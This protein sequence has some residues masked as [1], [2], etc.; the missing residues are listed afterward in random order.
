M[1]TNKN[2]SGIEECLKNW[3]KSL[4]HTSLTPCDIEE[5]SIHLMESYEELLLLNLSEQEAWIIASHRI[6]KPEVLNQE[7]EKVNADF[8]INRNWMMLLWGAVSL[9]I[10]QAV[11]IV[12]PMIFK[13]SIIN[14]FNPSDNAVFIKNQY[15]TIAVIV[16]ILFVL[17]AIRNGQIIRKFTNSL[18]K[19]ASLYGIIAIVAGLWA[20]FFSYIGFVKGIDIND[21]ESRRAFSYLNF[22]FYFPLISLAVFATIRYYSEEVIT[23]KKFC[24]NITWKHSLILGLLAQTPIQFSYSFS[25][26]DGS[27]IT[28]VIALSIFLY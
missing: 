1:D 13:N 21:N 3:K 4:V 24:R 25:G 28:F 22:G 8:S 14:Y 7:F 20:A 17:A 15:Y 6:G 26:R 12:A 10:L 2:H 9:L 16:V 18:T 11:F 19:Y 23:F 5:L 27:K